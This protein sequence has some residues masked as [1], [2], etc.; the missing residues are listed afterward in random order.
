MEYLHSLLQK[1]PTF[2]IPIDQLQQGAHKKQ[3]AFH[4]QT[5]IIAITNPLCNK[6]TD[7]N[8]PGIALTTR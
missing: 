1:H 8:P 3:S 2:L 6:S 5:H 7:T 4:K